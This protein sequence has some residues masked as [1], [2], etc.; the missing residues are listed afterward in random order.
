MRAAYLDTSLLV[1]IAFGEPGADRLQSKMNAID[2]L[3]SSTLLEAEFLS[4]VEREGVRSQAGTHLHPIR[5]IH[6]D[7]TLTGEINRILDHGFLRGADLHHLA[8]A[9][10][11]FPKPSEAFFLT[12][13]EKQDAAAIELGFKGLITL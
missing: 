7:R 6:P 9:L 13:D 3:Y 1:A 10:F 12:L 2:V 8:S 5:W 11:L 4:V